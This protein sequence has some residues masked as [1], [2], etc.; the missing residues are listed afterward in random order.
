MR[1]TTRTLL[2]VCRSTWAVDAML[3]L[4]SRQASRLHKA[5]LFCMLLSNIIQT[6]ESIVFVRLSLLGEALDTAE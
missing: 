3:P 1:T 5:Y 2:S 4:E 6:D